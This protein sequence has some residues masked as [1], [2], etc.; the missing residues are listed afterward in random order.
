MT[1]RVT[2]VDFVEPR[3]CPRDLHLP[4]RAHP[5]VH[6]DDRHDHGRP[7][8]GHRLRHHPVRS[9]RQPDRQDVRDRRQRRHLAEDGAYSG[10]NTASDDPD[11]QAVPDRHHWHDRLPYVDDH[12]DPDQRRTDRVRLHRERAADRSG[13]SDAPASRMAPTRRPR[14]DRDRTSPACTPGDRDHGHAGDDV[15]LD[16][17]VAT[18]TPT[19]TGRCA[20]SS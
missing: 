10:G 14:S 20:R 5:L 16:R 13:R 8:V 18:V 3:R 4:L 17:R 6:R 15:V 9:D 19:P 12:P 11:E 2:D 7:G 1:F